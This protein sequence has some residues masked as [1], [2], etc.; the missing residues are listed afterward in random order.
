MNKLIACWTWYK[1]KPLGNHFYSGP[2]EPNQTLVRCC[3]DLKDIQYF[4]EVAEGDRSDIR[5]E[6]TTLVFKPY[7][8]KLDILMSIEDVEQLYNKHNEIHN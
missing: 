7:G 4:Y 5:L 2:V 1:M 3:F 6:E 8:L